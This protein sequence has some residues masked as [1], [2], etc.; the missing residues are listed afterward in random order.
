MKQFRLIAALTL[1]IAMAVLEPGSAQTSSGVSAL[2]INVSPAKLELSMPPGISYNIPVTVQNGSS[3]P[4]HIL[5]SLVDFGLNQRGDYQFERVG[6]KPY[7]LMRWA[8]INPKEFDLAAGNFQQVR[9]SLAIPKESLSGEYS[10]IV[11]FA[12]RPTREQHGVA[13]SVRIATTVYVT[14]PGTVKIGG[15][16]AKMSAS[17]GPA[18]ENY[19]VLFRNTG[20]AHIY[21]GG[22]VEVRK[23][24]QVVDRITLP[25]NQ[26][27]ERGEDRLIE[28]SGKPL[29]AGKYQ[30]IALID[31]GGPQMTGGEIQFDKN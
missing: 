15:A 20:N 16:I 29:A 7:S 11:F 4:T 30:A 10:G 12:T 1:A 2:G 28:V 24:G 26:L 18:A 14:V 21:V 17:G 9:L 13:F 31:Y 25:P 27:V 23:D 5:A 19:R 3:S 8:T 22:T 6:S